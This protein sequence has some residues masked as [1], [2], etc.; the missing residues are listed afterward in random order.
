MA[1]V[2]LNSYSALLTAYLTSTSTVLPIAPAKVT[3]LA[4]LLGS[5][6]TTLAINDGTF[7][8]FVEVRVSGPIVTIARGVEGTA[9]RAFVAGTCAKAQLTASGLSYLICNSGCACVPIDMKAGLV[10]EQPTINV[11]WTHSWYFTG[12]YP[13]TATGITVPAWLTLDTT[14]L[15]T[16]LLTISGVPITAA[17]AALSIAVTG[18]GGSSEVITET[19]T[20]C[21]PTGL[22]S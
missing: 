6:Y 18:C 2:L 17:P 16:G 19:L 7:V 11:P 4:L 20:I 1:Y 15:A 9:P 3:E 10:I 21:S 22:G 8:E 5:N 12:T 13:F 14:K